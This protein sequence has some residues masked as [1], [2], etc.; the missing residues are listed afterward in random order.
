MPKFRTRFNVNEFDKP[1]VNITS[2][3]MTQQH[4]KDECDINIIVDRFTRTGLVT[5]INP[6]EPLY[7]DVS[8]VPDYITAFNIVTAAQESFDSLPSDVRKF[9]DNNPSNMV[10]FVQDPSNREQAI[11]LGLIPKPVAT[12]TS[13]E[14]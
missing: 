12:G 2:P 10:E 11:Q 3:T 4:F 1:V 14:S 8:N 6:R 5:N 7:M 13:E 9:F